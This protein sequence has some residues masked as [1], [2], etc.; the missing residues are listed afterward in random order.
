M[1]QKHIS[2]LA[3]TIIVIVAA[4]MLIAAQGFKDMSSIKTYVSSSY[5]PTLLCALIIIFGI[6]GIAED[7]LSMKDGE[8]GE[9]FEIGNVRNLFLTIGAVLFVLL[10][11]Q[12]LGL[13]YPAVFIAVG[14]LIF[15]FK[16][17][18]SSLGKHIGFCL[19]ISAILFI[20]FY[21]IFGVLLRV[22][23]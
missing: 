11:W 22:Q 19:L 16:P 2:L 14:V 1:K 12:F 3:Q 4:V 9:R 18:T 5:Y 6:W 15:F 10:I 23:F 17:R 7:L 21:L 13:F 8:K 20:L